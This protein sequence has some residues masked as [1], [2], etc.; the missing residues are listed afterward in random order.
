MQ[1]ARKKFAAINYDGFIYAI[2][3]K[4]HK[5]ATTTTVEKYDPDNDKWL[6]VSSMVTA[7]F[8]H[9]ACVMNRKIY[10][11][12]DLDACNKIINTGTIE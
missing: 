11:V 2:G 7:R 6:Y 9:A 8:S 3:S 5:S 4:C 10:A 12:G 1:M